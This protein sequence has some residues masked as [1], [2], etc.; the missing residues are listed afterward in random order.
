MLSMLPSVA[1]MVVQHFLVLQGRKLGRFLQ[2]ELAGVHSGCIFRRDRP[3]LFLFFIQEACIP[4]DTKWLGEPPNNNRA[5]RTHD[6][7]DSIGATYNPTLRDLLRLL[8]LAPVSMASSVGPSIPFSNKS[9][10]AHKDLD[11]S[12]NLDFFFSFMSCQ[13]GGQGTGR[14]PSTAFQQAGSDRPHGQ[15]RYGGCPGSLMVGHSEN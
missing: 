2:G 11:D 14:R 9:E 3:S 10:F 4:A 5:C 1:D 6:T 15:G 12:L 8:E 7:Q 13:I